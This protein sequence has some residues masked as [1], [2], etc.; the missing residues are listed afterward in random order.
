M[1]STSDYTLNIPKTPLK[2]TKLH[3]YSGTLV[4]EINC[5]CARRFSDERLR[6]RILNLSTSQ[7][8]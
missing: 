5:L 1:N 7:P 4:A 3:K 6:N 8:D 2:S